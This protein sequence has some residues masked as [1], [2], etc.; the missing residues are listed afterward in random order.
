MS[1]ITGITNISKI[2]D[3][4]GSNWKTYLIISVVLIIVILAI[5]WYNSVKN[6]KSAI[7]V[8]NSEGKTMKQI[9]K[10]NLPHNIIS[11]GQGHFSLTFKILLGNWEQTS[12]IKEI[13]SGGP[14]AIFLEPN[15]NNI[16]IYLITDTDARF[17]Q[18][19]DI[20]LFKWTYIGLTIGN[21]TMD[22]Y[23]DGLM[24]SSMPFNGQISEIIQDITI[25]GNG[26]FN[27]KLEDFAFHDRKLTANEI[28]SI[29]HPKR[30]NWAKYYWN[31]LKKNSSASYNSLIYY[32][33][34]PKE[35]EVC[36]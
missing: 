22:V 30:G 7:L 27:G 31:E 32:I 21:Q 2:K 23:R 8:G 5:V 24:I 15:V 33:N 4:I 14:L 34:P 1:E 25:N 13:Y 20:P 19:E 26:G 12:S 10:T 17:L 35:P 28:H 36:S 11:I 29:C 16:G 18:I 3:N 9:P 6:K